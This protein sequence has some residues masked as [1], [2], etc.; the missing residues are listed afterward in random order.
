MFIR[1]VLSCI[2]QLARPHGYVSKALY[3]IRVLGQ[4]KGLVSYTLRVLM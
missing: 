4:E 2:R 3:R 1:H